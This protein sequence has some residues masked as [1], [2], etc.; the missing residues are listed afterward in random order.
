[1]VLLHSTCN[2]IVS[3]IKRYSQNSLPLWVRSVTAR[4]FLDC[5]V[6][7]KNNKELKHKHNTH[8]KHAATNIS[9]CQPA[10]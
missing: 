3:L 2:D 5:Y 10:V 6:T 7:K 9:R 4:L 1:M 8:T